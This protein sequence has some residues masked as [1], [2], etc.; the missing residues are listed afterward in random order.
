MHIKRYHIY[1]V[2]YIRAAGAGL[3]AALREVFPSSFSPVCLKHLE[4][5]CVH[6]MAVKGEKANL[7]QKFVR[8][9][10]VAPT[11]TAYDARM[12]EVKQCMPKLYEYLSNSHPENWALSQTTSPRWGHTTSNTA[13]QSN[14]WFM[15]IRVSTSESIII[16]IINMYTCTCAAGTCRNSS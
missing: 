8:K 3:R 1:D 6:H 2:H 14:A 10:S 11:N 9:V 5:N 16:I 15:A 13:E 7:V 4:R 12:E